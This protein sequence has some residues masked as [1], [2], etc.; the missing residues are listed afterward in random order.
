LYDEEPAFRGFVFEVLS[1]RVFELMSKLEGLGSLR[2]EQRLAA[3]LLS[4]AGDDAVV[5]ISQARSAAHLG[6]AREVVFRAIRSLTTRG[7]LATSRGR[8]RLLDP[9]ALSA[10]A[11]GT[12]SDPSGT[13][14]TG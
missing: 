10:L 7:I 12:G 9:A 4:E 2:L 8:V 11:S 1:G 6:T 3:L 14:G 13:S 5:A